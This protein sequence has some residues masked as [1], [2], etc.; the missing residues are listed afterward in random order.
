MNEQRI[1]AYLS[2]IQELLTCPSGEENNV[3]NRNLELVDEE[4]VQMC[5]QVAAQMQAEGQ[6]NEARFVQNLAQQIATFLRSQGTETNSQQALTQFWG[7]L[8]KAEI[9]SGGNAVAVHEVMRQN[10]TLLVP[11]LAETISQWV[12][13]FLAE[14]PDEAEAIAGLVENTCTSIRQFPYGRYGEVLDIAL[15][16]YAVVLALR[17]NNPEKRARTLTNLG[18]AR[19]TQ[20]EMGINPAVNLD[21]A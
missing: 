4:F 2:L 6:E 21:E 20:A 9:E 13:G 1:Q 19:R 12:Q 3:L 14:N 16:G 10:M 15:G 5:R 17:E 7:Q 8:I 11:V 18:I